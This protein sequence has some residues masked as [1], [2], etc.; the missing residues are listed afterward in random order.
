MS[1][2][3]DIN[4]VDPVNT[5]TVHKKL[6]NQV[7]NKA[8]H[9]SHKYAVQVEP[10]YFEWDMFIATLEKEFPDILNEKLSHN[11]Q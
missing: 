9:I 11:S 7:R 2:I 8:I 4:F 1:C 10:L 3:I 6:M 5:R